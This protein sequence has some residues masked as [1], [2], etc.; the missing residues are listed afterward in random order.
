MAFTKELPVWNKAGTAPTV[1]KQT[2]GWAPTEKPPADWF[3]WQWNT[4]FLSLQELQQ[5]AIHKDGSNPFLGSQAF[6][7]AQGTPPFSVAS[8]TKVVKLN[9]DLLD[10]LD[11]ATAATA[12]TIAARDA[13][14][15]LFVRKISLSAAPTAGTDGTN[16]TYVDGA[17]AAIPATDTSSLAPKNA[18]TFTNTVTI[19]N[20]LIQQNLEI[21]RSGKDANGK[22]TIVDYKRQDGTLFMKST[23]SGAMDANGN[24][25]TR[26]E[27]Y[28]LANGVTVLKTVVYTR[29]FDVDGD[30][31]SEVY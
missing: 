9:A 12:S 14:G 27:I 21:N 18:P 26:T 8:T 1:T 5:N 30:L 22:M 31:I 24:Y 23:L 6:N 28:Y 25:P 13:N 10:G 19:T 15:D 29:T 3:N 2:N 20:D 11:S 4:T 17:I 7:V 16:K